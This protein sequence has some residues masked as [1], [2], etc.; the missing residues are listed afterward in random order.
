M[1]PAATNSTQADFTYTDVVNG[2]KFQCI[3]DGGSPSNCNKNGITYKKLAD[4]VHTFSVQA[5]TDKS[6]WSAAATYTW[7][8]D[9]VAPV[10]T[11]TFPTNGQ[12]AGPVGWSGTC[13]GGPGIC[14]TVA[15]ATG[16]QKFEISIIEFKTGGKYWNGSAFLSSS[17]IFNLATVAGNAWRL[18]MPIPANGTYLTTIPSHRQRRQ[19]ERQPV[20]VVHDPQHAAAGAEH[21]RQA[22]RSDHLDERVVRVLRHPSGR[23]VQ[24]FTRR[25]RC[26]VACTS[27]TPPY[28]GLAQGQHSFAVTAYDAQLNASTPATYSWVIDVS[29][30]AV[31]GTAIGTLYP[32]VSSPVN[33]SITNPY[34][35]ALHITGVERHRQRR[36]PRSRCVAERRTSRSRSS[37]MRRLP[38][39][40]DDPG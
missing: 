33:L 11:L 25:R 24:V 6:A 21:H 1:P 8:V 7:T 31:N 28:T 40:G 35:F 14:G 2:V 36:Q 30:F 13:A 23:H 19:R 26:A 16:L 4:G 9:T 27:P 32:G 10:V 39:V 3:L 20:D 34:N 37:C 29:G 22:D 38:A 17:Q 12:T 5:S 18:P 15:D